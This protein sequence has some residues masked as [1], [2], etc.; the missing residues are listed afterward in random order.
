VR[1]V[2]H[3]AALAAALA[4]PGLA[5]AGDPQLAVTIQPESPIVVESGGR[6]EAIVTL[7]VRNDEDRAVRVDAL[8]LVYFERDVAVKV[9]ERASELFTS[10]G[11][12]SDPRVEPHGDATW[13]GLCVEPPTAATDRVRLEL[14]L[15]QRRGLR[16]VRA[17]QAVDVPLRAPASIPALGLPFS[18]AWRVTQGHTCDSN[19]RHSPLGSEFAWD[20]AAVPDARGGVAAASLGRPILAPVSGKVVTAVSDVED[21]AAGSEYPRRSIAATL[22]EPLWYFGNF[23]VIDGGESFVLLAHLLRGSIAVKPGDVVKQGDRLALAG[24]SGNTTIPH[25]HLQVMDRADPAD[26]AVSGLPARFHDYVEATSRGE[27]DQRE[28]LVRR[29]KSGD[30]PLGSVVFSAPPADPSSPSR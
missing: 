29:I 4:I 5:G 8:R 2:F 1:H 28:S 22:R 23:I 18:G 6:R 25:L 7:E 17:R 10:I 11:L 14:D 3:R 20:F 30:P 26:P 9:V 27:G 16:V 21:N 19:H 13:A 15:V 24:N 12:E